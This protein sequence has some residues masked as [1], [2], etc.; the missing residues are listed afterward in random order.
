MFEKLKKRQEEFLK[1]GVPGNDLSVYYN[2]EEVYR[3]HAGV[4]D[5]ESGT[6]MTEKNGTICIPARNWLRARRR[7]S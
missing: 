3:H 6:P 2:G 4:S 5:K 1:L 7:C